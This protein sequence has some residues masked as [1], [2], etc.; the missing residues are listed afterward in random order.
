MHSEEKWMWSFRAMQNYIHVT[1]LCNTLDAFLPSAI[2]VNARKTLSAFVSLRSCLLAHK[3]M[4]EVDNSDGYK[5]KAQKFMYVQISIALV[6]L[7]Y[8]RSKRVLRERVLVSVE[9]WGWLE[10]SGAPCW[11]QQKSPRNGDK[12][13]LWACVWGLCERR[14]RVSLS[15]GWALPGHRKGSGDHPTFTQ[16]KRLNVLTLY[17]ALFK[18]A[19]EVTQLFKRKTLVLQHD[20]PLLERDIGLLHTCTRNQCYCTVVHC[21]F[22]T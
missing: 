8:K 11:I 22:I 3:P 19:A 20:C 21:N 15:G 6:V 16:F 14:S 7:S 4:V 5:W 17:S 10:V 12:E 13:P 18:T 1:L 9:L 2:S